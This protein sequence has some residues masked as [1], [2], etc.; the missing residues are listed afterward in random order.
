VSV[1][2]AAILLNARDHQQYD[3]ALGD[4]H[5]YHNRSCRHRPVA[6]HCR[7]QRATA[8]VLSSGVWVE[9]DGH[10]VCVRSHNPQVWYAANGA[11]PCAD[12]QRAPERRC[13]HRLARG[14]YLR[15]AEV[16]RQESLS[17]PTGLGDTTAEV[18]PDASPDIDPCS[19]EERSVAMA[20]IIVPAFFPHPLQE[21]LQAGEVVTEQE[22]LARLHTVIPLIEHL[23]SAVHTASEHEDATRVLTA[24]LVSL[25]F[26]A[27]QEPAVLLE[28]WYEAVHDKLI[29]A[30]KARVRNARKE[31]R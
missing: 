16:L 20:S 2:E 7:I 31:D 19:R 25:A 11:C 29:T 14:L 12:H 6:C 22:L 23:L 18:P 9:E 27:L 28:T 17:S 3:A 30:A 24:P 5:A 4:D 8:L 13:K 26:P 15:A 10:T 1:Q 21:S